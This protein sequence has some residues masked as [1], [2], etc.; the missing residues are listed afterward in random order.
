MRPGSADVRPGY[1]HG[2]RRGIGDGKSMTEP[3]T[4]LF[5]CTKYDVGM[6]CRVRGA[7]LSTLRDV[8]DEVTCE[9]YLITSTYHQMSRGW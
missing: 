4:E 3:Q 2:A 5:P 9:M 6:L 8:L 1:L 7:K